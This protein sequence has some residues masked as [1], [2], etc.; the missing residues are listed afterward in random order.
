RSTQKGGRQKADGALAGGI[1][2]RH[3]KIASRITYQIATPTA[4]RD[5]VVDQKR[6]ILCSTSADFIEVFSWVTDSSAARRRSVEAAA[7]LEFPGG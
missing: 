7:S 3:H 1:S 2:F 6:T 5:K 4:K